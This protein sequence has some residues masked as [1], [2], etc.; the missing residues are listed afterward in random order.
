MQ[1]YLKALLSY[2]SLQKLPKLNIE[3]LGKVGALA[4]IFAQTT[5]RT[6]TRNIN[7]RREPLSPSHRDKELDGECS[8]EPGQP[9][10]YSHGILVVDDGSALGMCKS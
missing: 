3:A 2:M 5:M 8:R 10:A 9:A 7:V 6:G 1:V 4:D